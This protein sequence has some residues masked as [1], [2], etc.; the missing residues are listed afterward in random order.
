[1]FSAF[2]D[3]DDPCWQDMEGSDVCGLLA[4][5]LVDFQNCGKNSK[6]IRRI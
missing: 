2:D 3:K 6:G 4:K 1:L 5:T